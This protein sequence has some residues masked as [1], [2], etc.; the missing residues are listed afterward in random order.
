MYPALA[1]NATVYAEL[2]DHETATALLLELADKWSAKALAYAAPA[3]MAIAWLE[4]LGAD[5][6]RATYDT[7]TAQTAW[8]RGARALADEDFSTAVEVYGGTGASSD[9]AAAQFY[10]ARKLVEAGRR[11]E[12]DLFLHPALS[13]YRSVGATRRVQQGEALLAATA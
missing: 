2:D 13:F 9:L 6:W 5:L 4:H 11:A 10:A 3:D 7:P 8:L 1:I 12:A